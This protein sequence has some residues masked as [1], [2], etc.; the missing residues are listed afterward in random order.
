VG[1]VPRRFLMD[2]PGRCHLRS[3]NNEAACSL[4]CPVWNARPAARTVRLSETFRAKFEH[5]YTGV[6]QC[7]QVLELRFLSRHQ[8]ALIPTLVTSTC[9]VVVT[10][11]WQ[12]TTGNC[13]RTTC[14][15]HYSAPSNR[16]RSASK[17]WSR[18]QAAKELTVQKMQ[19][20]RN[21]LRPPAP[22]PERYARCPPRGIHRGLRKPGM[23]H[24]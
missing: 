22:S 20:Q 1:P 15:C 14:H 5:P 13:S 11:N 8:S 6:R 12:L 3:P 2:P 23:S 4:K 17:V 10:D 7:C 19:R 9:S 16:P 24:G 21:L 18:L